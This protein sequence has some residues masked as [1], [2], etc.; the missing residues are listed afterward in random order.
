MSLFSLIPDAIGAENLFI[1]NLEFNHSRSGSP[2]LRFDLGI[3]E[4]ETNMVIRQMRLS[5]GAIR[6]PQVKLGRRKLDQAL[7]GTKTARRL[8]SLLCYVVTSYGFPIELRS[9]KWA[10]G[11][12]KLTEMKLRKQ[13]EENDN[14]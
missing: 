4:G 7:L 13:L 9:E 5:G 12:I 6:P 10:I 3:S 2:Y 11:R 8:Y 14:K 1:F